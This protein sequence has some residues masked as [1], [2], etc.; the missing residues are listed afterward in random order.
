MKNLSSFLHDLFPKKTSSAPQASLSALALL[1]EG[2]AAMLTCD[3]VFELIDQFSERAARGEAVAYLM[4]VVQAH[5]E[6]CPD[7]REQY[8]ALERVLKAG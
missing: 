7:C 8:E 3:Q 4:P 2:Q 5:L 6:L 1:V